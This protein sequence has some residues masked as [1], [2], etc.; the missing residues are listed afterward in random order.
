LEIIAE[1]ERLTTI[2]DHI[3]AAFRTKL[4]L[5]DRLRQSIL[6]RAFEGKL[7][8]QDPSDEPASWLLEKILEEKQKE[9]KKLKPFKRVDRKKRTMP[10]E[11]RR[12]FEVLTEESTQLAPEELLRKANF[13]EETVDEF[14]QELRDEVKK[15]RIIEIRPNEIDVYLKVVQNENK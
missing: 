7:V 13:S 9:K 12:L 4:N 5:A 2:A 8:P 6:K 14:Y 1:I 11:R 10:K 15:S 3:D